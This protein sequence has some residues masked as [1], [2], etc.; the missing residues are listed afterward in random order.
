MRA[1]S[2]G[3]AT[4]WI[5]TSSKRRRNVGMQWANALEE[6]LRRPICMHKTREH[7]MGNVQGR[8]PVDTL[9]TPLKQLLR[10]NAGA[11]PTLQ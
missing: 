6:P 9:E 1:H 2:L 5:E 4:V 3:M 7:V 11:I 10:T 8:I